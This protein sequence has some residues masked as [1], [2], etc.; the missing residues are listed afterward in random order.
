MKIND[1]LTEA[2]RVDPATMKARQ[3]RTAA[4]NQNKQQA[5]QAQQ[6]APEQEPA[7][8]QSKPTMKI[9]DP[10]YNPAMKPTAT[11]HK[12]DPNNPNY[13]K[14]L[15]AAAAQDRAAGRTPDQPEQKPEQKP[16]Q[17]PAQAKPSQEKPPAQP[18]TQTPV[19]GAPEEDEPTTAKK[20][21]SNKSGIGSFFK[22]LGMDQ[23]AGAFDTAKASNINPNIEQEVQNLPDIS[24]LTA[25]QRAELKKQLQASMAS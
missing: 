21:P 17:E 18:I 19:Q 3:A 14:N 15:D 2:P 11:V 25:A 8:A 9:A 7:P 6:P 13:Q 4:F 12:G 22:G 23:T 1:V 10:T 20:L 16:K 5:Q 24:K